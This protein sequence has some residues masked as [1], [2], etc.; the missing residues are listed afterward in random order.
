[1]VEERVYCRHVREHSQRQGCLGGSRVD[2]TPSHVR[3]G[4][5]VVGIVEETACSSQEAQKRV[6][7]KDQVTK[8]VDY[9][10][11]AAGS[12]TAQFLG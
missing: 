6:D 1:M 12:R 4:E 7:E 5:V 10:G 3:R 9:T 8:M 11:R 2:K